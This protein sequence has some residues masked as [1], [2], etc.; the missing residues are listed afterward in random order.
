[1]RENQDI[2]KSIEWMKRGLKI[3]D[4]YKIFNVPNKR[5]KKIREAIEFLKRLNERYA[6]FLN[7]IKEKPDK[8]KTEE[9]F[10]LL[11]ADIFS[12]LAISIK[13]A[14]ED[15]IKYSL[16]E[17]RATLDLIFL[18]LFTI[19]S[20]P[21][22]SAE[23]DEDIN[24][25]A[26]AILS[27]YWGKMS[28][29]KNFDRLVL[30]DL[31]VKKGDVERLVK[32]TVHEL[33]RKFYDEIIEE[34]GLN[35]KLSSNSNK[36]EMLERLLDEFLVELMK[37]DVENWKENAKESFSPKLFYF[38]LMGHDDIIL[39]AC[40]K[41]KDRLL[42]ELQVKLGI[43][44]KLTPELKCKLSQLAFYT[45]NAMSYW[46]NEFARCKY[47]ENEATIYAVYSRPDTP[48]MKKLI[49]YQMQGDKLNAINSCV[50]ESFEHNGK[51]PKNNYF[52]DIIYSEIYTKLNDY[53]HANLVEE[54]TVTDWFF[55]FYVPT[56]KT[57][58]CILSVYLP[59]G[60]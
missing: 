60:D 7:S 12:E 57:L 35:K 49:K 38:T 59:H 51:K 45:P 16:R 29:F 46:G 30:S 15:Y 18:G 22:G 36:N 56:V 3:S 58:D 34:F 37:M 5:N 8:G 39:R 23:S 55:H 50:K 33:S 6:S 41:H 4:F 17:I 11:F 13:L 14:G 24:P 43:N 40:D 27:G 25:M 1:M 44:G 26:N 32:E 2:K 53:V 9:F 19:S 48:E 10:G 47:C 31:V 42:E 52:G 21:G 54:P 20:W 28:T